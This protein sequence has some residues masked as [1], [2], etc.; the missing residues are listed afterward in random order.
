MEV[1]KNAPEEY[2]IIST[3]V[4]IEMDYGH[5]SAIT[6]RIF[7]SLSSHSSE[8]INIFF[9][10]LCLYPIASNCEVASNFSP[11]NN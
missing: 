8:L 2:S 9:T 5:T 6:P 3:L 1:V 4:I 7:L 10:S 11:L